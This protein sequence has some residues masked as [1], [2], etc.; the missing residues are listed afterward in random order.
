MGATG[1]RPAQGGNLLGVLAVGAVLGLLLG[2][3][4]FI[5]SMVTGDPGSM[6]RGF[7]EFYGLVF[8]GG[9]FFVLCWLLVAIAKSNTAVRRRATRIFLIGLGVSL[10][11]VGYATWRVIEQHHL[12]VQGLAATSDWRFEFDDDL[13]EA[14]RAW[15]RE[16]GGPQIQRAV[17]HLWSLDPDADGR[18]DSDPPILRVLDDSGWSDRGV[19]VLDLDKDL[20]VD[21]LE[22]R[23]T[24]GPREGEIWCIPIV[25]HDDD[26][27]WAR[28]AWEQALPEQCA[29]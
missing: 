1:E 12:E 8:A 18:P 5:G 24:S 6:D 26:P 28:A 11:L 13:D 2:L 7:G 21:H 9:S 27:E 22:W 4:V 25:V 29:G 20:V 23:P 19:L 17:T 10:A 14:R 16:N 15:N 3:H